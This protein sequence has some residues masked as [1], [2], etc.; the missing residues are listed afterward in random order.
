MADDLLDPRL[1]ERTQDALD[2][3]GAGAPWPGEREPQPPDLAFAPWQD[4]ER[5]RRL[6]DQV[7]ER[8]AQDVE[9]RARNPAAAVVER[10]GL[11]RGGERHAAVAPP[12]MGRE[13][14]LGGPVGAGLRDV[15][16]QDEAAGGEPAGRRLDVEIG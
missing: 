10:L 13:K 5:Q 15:V 4:A 12:R 7:R 6:P 8:S 14:I 2:M 16:D 1:R 3:Q 11:V 9:I